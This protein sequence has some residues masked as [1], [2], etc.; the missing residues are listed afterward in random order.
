MKSLQF[1][2][3]KNILNSHFYALLIDFSIIFFR[4]SYLAKWVKVIQISSLNDDDDD[5]S[6][7]NKSL[8]FACSLRMN[9]SF[10]RNESMRINY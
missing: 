5:D 4:E 8:V 9:F 6:S 10:V 2:G 1:F 3:K 7:T